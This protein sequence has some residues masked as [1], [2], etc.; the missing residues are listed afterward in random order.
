[1][2]LVGKIF[3]VLILIMSVVWMGF[4]MS[5]YATHRNWRDLVLR[6]K[7]VGSKPRGLKFQ[8]EDKE[9]R[10]DELKDQVSRLEDKLVTVSTSAR[11][12]ETKLRQSVQQLEE[13]VREKNG[14]LAERTQAAS[15]AVSA[16]E[17]TQAAA[18]GLRD[19]LAKVREEVRQARD[20]RDALDAAVVRLKDELHDAKNDH[21]SLVEKHGELAAEHAVAMEVLRRH[22]IP[23]HDTS[24]PRVFGVV[25][26]V[27]GTNLV[28]ISLGSDDGL[29]EGHTLEVFR[30]AAAGASSYRGK[31]EV[32]QTSPDKSVCKV[33]TIQ[34]GSIQ[35]GD[36]VATRLIN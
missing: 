10:I 21:K 34:E 29:R 28:E 24:A 19:E 18:D 26:A 25:L 31:I 1:M 14:L 7:A 5:V 2:N 22:E 4:T 30:I 17:A 23:T 3:I 36:R 27:R 8:L 12:T 16:M 32:I 33:T 13:E 9:K 15:D 11:D 20:D 6:E 35:R